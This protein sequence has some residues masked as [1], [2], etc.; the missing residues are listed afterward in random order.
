MSSKEK[1]IEFLT[2]LKQEKEAR[3]DQL[4]QALT[5]RK[6]TV[7]RFWGLLASLKSFKAQLSREG[8]STVPA[9][10]IHHEKL[11]ILRDHELMVTSLKGMYKEVS[12][13]VW[14]LKQ[15]IKGL[16]EQ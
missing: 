2:N 4:D 8:K 3:K 9:I 6:S 5:V 10:A 12:D 1:V 16:E 14:E 15:M 13:E 7:K 11:E